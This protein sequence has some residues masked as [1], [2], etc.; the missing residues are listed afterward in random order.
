MLY[1]VLAVDRDADAAAIKKAYIKLARKTHPDKCPG[2]DS[3]HARFQEVGRAYATLCDPEKRKL[4]DATGSVDDA[5]TI[6]R[7]ASWDEFWRDFYTRVTTGKLDA[8]ASSYRGSAEEARDLLRTYQEVKG[9]M[10]KILDRMMFCTAED[11]PRFRELL[12]AVFQY[13][14]IVH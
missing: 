1:E 3:A 7:N 8:L 5:S 2:D 13:S 12:Q 4:Y 14:N 11:E 6:G 9:D 10:G